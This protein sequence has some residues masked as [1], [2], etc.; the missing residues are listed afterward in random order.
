MPAFLERN[1]QLITL[2]MLTYLD[3][4]FL[5]RS[6]EFLWQE[7]HTALATQEEADAEV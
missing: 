2:S 3:L 1:L 6:R 7:G 4:F 5:Y